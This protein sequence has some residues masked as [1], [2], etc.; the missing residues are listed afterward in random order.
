[1]RTRATYQRVPP[2]PN[3]L[4]W[5]FSSPKPDAVWVA[6]ITFVP[7]RAGWL[8]LAAVLDMHTRQIVGWA[9]GERPDQKLASAALRMALDRRGPAS[10]AIHHSDQGSQYTSGAY[11]AELKAAGL[12]PSMSRKGMPYD[13]AVME[14]FFSSLKQELTHHER[15]AD[16]DEARGKLFDYIEIFYNRQR[17]HS[18]LGY[19]TPVEQERL[20]SA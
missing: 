13:N 18:S 7:T 5:P 16:L 2:A 14:S 15:F 12:Q 8:H 10:G 9:M 6:D 11:Q 19:R 3:L 20:A 1:M 17:L 4:A